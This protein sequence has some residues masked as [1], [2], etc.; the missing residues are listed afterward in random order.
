MLSAVGWRRRFD[1]QDQVPRTHRPDWP[2]G[3]ILSSERYSGGVES[4]TDHALSFASLQVRDLDAA[5]TFYTD[6]LGFAVDEGTGPPHA[7]VFRMGSRTA[8]AVREPLV[9]LDAAERLGWGS[10]LWFDVD[11]VAALYER[12]SERAP[13]AG[14]TIFDDLGPGGFGPQFS[15][16]DPDGYTLVFHQTDD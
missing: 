6:V 7:V 14:G 1:R 11:D 8:F 4:T 10:Q 2:N 3:Q 12:V 13:A 5:R 15:V 9:D 16:R